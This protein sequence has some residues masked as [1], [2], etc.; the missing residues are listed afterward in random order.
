MMAESEGNAYIV[1]FATV[2]FKLF[3]TWLGLD[4]GP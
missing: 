4:F 3:S 1:P 2:M